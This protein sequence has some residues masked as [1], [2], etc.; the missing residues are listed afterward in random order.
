MSKSP[1]VATQFHKDVFAAVM[2]ATKAG[3]TLFTRLTALLTNKYGEVAPTYEQ[4]R[5]DHAMLNQLAK[6][7]GLKDNQFGRKA[8]NNAIKSLYNELPVSQSAEA[9][10]KRAQR[11]DKTSTGPAKKTVGTR[12][13]SHAETIEQFISRVGVYKALEACTAILAAA[14]ETEAVAKGIKAAMGSPMK[15]AA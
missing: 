1:I 9:I 5:G 15:K 2:T 4:F 7:R 11:P 3:E 10:A 6:D 12:A 14:T 8:F 13:P